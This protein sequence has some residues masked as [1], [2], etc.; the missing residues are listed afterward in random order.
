MYVP[1]ELEGTFKIKANSNE[2]MVT[3][4]N[5]ILIQELNERKDLIKMGDGESSS[6]SDSAPSEDNLDVKELLKN[7]PVVDKT[8]KKKLK[9]END[10]DIR[11]QT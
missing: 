10:K 6:G 2:S 9:I 11:K 1:T 5:N 7:L 4:I 3:S 8:L